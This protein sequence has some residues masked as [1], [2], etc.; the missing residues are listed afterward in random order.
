MH[1]N[2]LRRLKLCLLGICLNSAGMFGQDATLALQISDS[3]LIPEG[4]AYHE[5]TKTFYLSSIHQRKIIA[6]DTESGQVRNFIRPEQ[7]GFMGGV[8]LQIDQ[9][10]DLLYAL[11]FSKIDSI[12]HTG[13]YVYDLKTSALILRIKQA[14]TEKKLFNDLVLDRK[15]NLFISDTERGAIWKLGKGETELELFYS[16][17]EMYPNGIT[18]DPAKNIIYVASWNDGILAIDVDDP[19]EVESIHQDVVVSQGIDGLYFYKGDLIAIHNGKQEKIVR[20]HLE[21]DGSCLEWQEI[22]ANNKYFQIPTTGTIVGREFYCLANSQLDQ[23]N[24]ET[25]TIK[26]GAELT[27]TYILKYD[28]RNKDRK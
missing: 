19:E 1:S 17:P 7:N 13:L 12:Y 22:D 15:G 14:D 2:C 11:C 9:Q 27:P 3:L 5:A 16:D 23:L 20:Y 18:I 8:G 4:V 21:K 10:G 25:N 6:V 26:K 28:L 24:Q